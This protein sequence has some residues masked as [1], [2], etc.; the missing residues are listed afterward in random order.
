MVS[1]DEVIA[2]VSTLDGVLILRPQPG[3]GSPPISWGDVFCYYAPDGQVP[4]GQPFATVV[5]KC[6]P[7]EDV[8]ELDRPGTFRLNIAVGRHAMAAVLG[9]GA[10]AVPA[11][12]AS[13][14]WTAH[15]VYGQLGW[16]AVI[17]PGERT[18]GEALSLLQSAH[19]LARAR[20][21]RRD[22]AGERG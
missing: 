4:S 20:H 9:E 22:D 19:A 13:D 14:T 11:G 16:V 1:I 12:G 8:P 17:D 10:G 3:D 2:H 21:D 5:T 6:Y 7:D 18:T 15:P